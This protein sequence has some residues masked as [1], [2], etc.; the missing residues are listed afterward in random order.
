[1]LDWFELNSFNL[2]KKKNLTQKRKNTNDTLMRSHAFK[3]NQY[4]EGE[5]Y[6]VQSYQEYLWLKSENNNEHF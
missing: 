4:F 3:I 2:S 6:V 5:F 1:M